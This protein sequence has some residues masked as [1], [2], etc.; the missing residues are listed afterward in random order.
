MD[1]ISIRRLSVMAVFVVYTNKMDVLDRI[2]YD[3]KFQETAVKSKTKDFNPIQDI[4]G[5]K[6]KAIDFT[7]NILKVYPELMDGNGS[8]LFYILNA[9]ETKKVGVL[10]NSFKVFMENSPTKIYST[11]LSG[12]EP[13]YM[14]VDPIFSWARYIRK[15][16]KCYIY[17]PILEANNKAL[18]KF[19][20]NKQ[21]FLGDK[22]VLLS[23][24]RPLCYTNTGENIAHLLPYIAY[25][26][27]FF[28]NC[29][30]YTFSEIMAGSTHNA[31]LEAVEAD[32]TKYYQKLLSST[33]GLS[34]TKLFAKPTEIVNHF[35]VDVLKTMFSE[36][37]NPE[38]IVRIRNNVISSDQ[39]N[40][41]QK[42]IND[43]IAV[44]E[45]TVMKGFTQVI[46]NLA[47]IIMKSNPVV[48]TF[49]KIPK[50]SANNLNEY[51]LSQWT[52]YALSGGRAPFM[53]NS[54]LSYVAIGDATKHTRIDALPP[55]EL[56]TEV[57]TLSIGAKRPFTNSSIGLNMCAAYVKQKFMEYQ[58]DVLNDF[59]ISIDE[60]FM[61]TDKLG[62]D[63]MDRIIT[64]LFVNGIYAKNW[65]EVKKLFDILMNNYRFRQTFTDIMNLPT[66]LKRFGDNA[67]GANIMAAYILSFIPEWLLK[68]V[69]T[70][71]AVA[72]IE[73][74]R[75]ISINVSL[76][77]PMAFFA[78]EHNF[79]PIR[80]EKLLALETAI[81][82]MHNKSYTNFVNNVAKEFQVSVLSNAYIQQPYV[83]GTS[84]NISVY[85]I[86]G[87]DLV[88][89]A[90]LSN[91]LLRAYWFVYYTQGTCSNM[92]VF[93]DWAK[94]IDNQHAFDMI[95][96]AF[97]DKEFG[98]IKSVLTNKYEEL[99]ASNNVP[100]LLANYE[101]NADGSW[102]VKPSPYF[103]ELTLPSGMSLINFFS[104]YSYPG[105]HAKN[106][107]DNELVVKPIAFKDGAFIAE[108]AL[109]NTAKFGSNHTSATISEFGIKYNLPY[110]D[111]NAAMDDFG[112]DIT[113]PPGYKLIVLTTD[114]G[115]Q[116]QNDVYFLYTTFVANKF[117]RRN[118]KNRYDDIIDS[119]EQAPSRGFKTQK[120]I[121]MDRNRMKINGLN[122]VPIPNV[123]SQ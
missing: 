75:T 111:F 62:K 3:Q 66:L 46:S 38:N 44:T 57:A 14:D 93:Y 85:A 43:Q 24:I 41:L 109:Y 86:G 81:M 91:P 54:D 45:N 11:I 19:I 107:M 18:Q 9:G 77:C 17:E 53:I 56:L 74:P 84:D 96:L 26:Y 100:L 106:I 55:Q 7:N 40:E 78:Q 2:E 60:S 12:T 79:N 95:A 30:N 121:G 73:L 28:I 32:F 117:G 90:G 99:I 110:Y 105:S 76:F 113:A 4:L 48:K 22:A 72:G 36:M 116:T 67:Y 10:Y 89:K 31:F 51:E 88:S 70:N 98:T 20:N 115:T 63:S 29:N 37:L 82:Y 25:L 35:S 39:T 15:Y 27:N 34:L 16:K 119:V 71:G 64:G 83:K 49:N 21:L 112:V 104:L 13:F 102:F 80:V 5:H 120:G 101:F 68:F 65:N 69:I 97:K 1:T 94:M 87:R 114:S 47:D 52:A 50:F 123:S 33:D 8:T 58:T 122:K 108:H 59:P 61:D 103:I 23:E 42:T 92:E 6:Y 118:Y